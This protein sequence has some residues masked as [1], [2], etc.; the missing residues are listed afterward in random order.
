MSEISSTRFFSKKQILSLLDAAMGRTLLDVDSRHLFL[1]YEKMEKVTG[2]AGNIVEQSILG[3]EPDNRQDVDIYI[4]GIGYEIKTTGMVVPKDKNSA[5]LY[6]CKE[7]VSVTA[8]SIQKIVNEEFENSNFWHKLEHLLW[9]YYLY[10]AESTVKPAEYKL[11]PLLKFQLFEFDETDK[12]RLKHDWL[13][14]RDFLISIHREYP[15]EEGRKSQYPYLSSKLR[16]V[17]LVI[18][19][20]PKY[21]NPPRFRLKRDFAS[22]IAGNLFLKNNK[23]PLV[24]LAKPIMDYSD[25]D[26]KCEELNKLY[27]GKTFS[28][29]ADLLNVSIETPGSVADKESEDT[30]SNKVPLKNFAEMVVLKMFESDATSLNQIDDFRK[31]GLIAKSLPLDNKGEPKESMKMYTPNFKDWMS[32][33]TFSDSYIRNYFS[34]HQFLLI[35]YQYIHPKK[36][37]KTPDFIKF[38]GF[39]RVYLTDDFIDTSVWKFWNDVRILIKE[40]KLKVVKLFNKNNEP[41][42]NPKSGTQRE[43]TN[44]PKEAQYDVFMRGSATKSEEKYKTLELCGHKMLPQE[45][46]LSKKVT[47]NLFKHQKI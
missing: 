31:I 30:A 47:Y 10:N 4:D 28:E 46:W 29:I 38:V 32:E 42:I 5:Y 34:E 23:V 11:F 9:V 1:Q 33:K 7:P 39:K 22:E 8:V 16:K 45:I 21:P 41:I 26:R 24:K 20:A 2:L 18:D 6:E 25:I 43:A 37:V 12:L 36:N 3:C 40:K 27:S 15:T 17:L 14:V 35:V 44:F 13:L 19:T